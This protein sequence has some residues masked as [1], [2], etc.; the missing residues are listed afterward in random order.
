MTPSAACIAFIKAH[1]QF[2]PTAYLPTKRDVWTIGYGHTSGV[3]PG[4]T[5]TLAQ[6]LAWLAEDMMWAADAVRKLV[7]VPLTQT[8]FDA[9][10]SFVFNVGADIDED[11]V[12]EGFG[13]STLLRKLN[14]G[15]YAGAAAEFDKWIYQKKRKLPGLVT[16][17]AAERKMFEG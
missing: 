11:T 3:K 5:C 2:R 8:Q 7:T 14:R 10:V 13:D 6:A 16:R 4:D 1:E 12:A 17:R 9:L 15:D